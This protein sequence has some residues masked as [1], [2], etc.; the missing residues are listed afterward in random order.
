MEANVRTL[1][2]IAT[3]AGIL[4][5]ACSRRERR[6]RYRLDALIARHGA[7]AGVACHCPGTDGRV[8]VSGVCGVVERCDV[9][10][11]ELWTLFPA[12]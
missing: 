3:R 6:G 1:G 2:G 7:K 5:V 11:P 10:F 12:R 8:R 9:L 4:A